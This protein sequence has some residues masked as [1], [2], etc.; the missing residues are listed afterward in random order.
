[1]ILLSLCLAVFTTA[2]NSTAVMNAL[3]VMQNDLH[4]AAI[5]LQWIINA[6]LLGAAA[7]FIAG[8][9]LG[10]VFGHRKI[11]ILG[12]SLFI[13]ASIFI[14]IATGP[15]ELITGRSLQGI[16]A[17]LIIPA[18]MAIIPVSFAGEARKFAFSAW[19]AMLGL[20]SAFGPL[21]GGFMVHVLG[22]RALFLANVPILII[23]LGLLIFFLR[24]KPDKNYKAAMDVPGLVLLILGLVPVVL[25]LVEGNKWGWI[26]PVTLSI[27]VF[28]LVMLFLFY[29]V[30]NRQPNPLINFKFFKNKLFVIGNTGMFISAFSLIAV[31][32]FLNL[33]L[34]N[35]NLLNYSPLKA[36]LALLPASLGM[37][38]ISILA[39]YFI[40]RFGPRWL[41]ASAMF[42]LAISFWGLHYVTANTRYWYLFF[43]IL[44]C[45]IGLGFGYANFPRIGVETLPED[46]LGQASGTLSTANFLGSVFSAA[47][48]TI[49]FVHAGQ[50]SDLHGFTTVMVFYTMVALI[51]M[52]MC[53]WLLPIKAS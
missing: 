52:L 24:P 47:L 4:L 38:L 26:N 11:L 19:S 10:D 29:R 36:G 53:L 13:L 12:I 18:T 32:Y 42:L 51:G 14:A 41:L 27:S 1:M 25:A 7:L 49:I 46:S 21:G 28:G 15:V 43:P 50:H 33:Y 34:Q 20:G 35:P 16:G 6:Y 23:S 37:F 39:N 45:G 22:W 40:N 31:L 30:E 9:R 3:P 5:N 44:L 8:G 2:F 48:G 17:A